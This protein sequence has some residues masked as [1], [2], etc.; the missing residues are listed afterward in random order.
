MEKRLLNKV[1]IVTGSS[2]GN[3]R[4]IALRFAMEGANVVVNYITHEK[5]AKNVA[6]EIEKL[7]SKAI[8]VRADV[9]KA[10]DVDQLVKATIDAFGKVDILVNNAG[11][12]LEKPLLET[13]EEE[14]DRVIDVNLKSVFLCTKRVVPEMLKQGK[15]KIINISSIDAIVAEPH[16]CAYCASKGGVSSLTRALALEL[17]PKKINVNAI[18]PG[19]IDTPMIAK[20]LK[21]PEMKKSLIERTPFGR[22]GKPEDVAAAAVFLA[23][24]ETEFINGITLVVDGGWLIL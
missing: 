12:F 8:V 21:D 14:W 11:I 7:G 19:Q 20:W 6:K 18:A 13:T 17:A 15:G 9:S 10:S 5:E 24:D 23:L 3:G 22:I 16:T 2:S 4:A 1:A